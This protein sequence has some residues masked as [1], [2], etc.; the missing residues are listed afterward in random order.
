M[1][2]SDFDYTLP[3]ALIAQHPLDRRSA[4]RLMLVNKENGEVTHRHFYD[5][6]DELNTGGV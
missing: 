3:E 5:I 6:I 4:S 2:T 1:K